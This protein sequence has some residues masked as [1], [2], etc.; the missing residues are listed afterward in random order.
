MP[1]PADLTVR[2]L[3]TTGPARVTPDQPVQ[4]ALD[5]MNSRRVGAVLVADADDKLVG[6]FTE[7]DFLRQAVQAGSQWHTSPIRDWM[8]P[9]PYTIHPD[10]G[11]EEAVASLERLRVRHLPVVENGRLVGIITTRALMAHRAE[12]LNEIVRDRTREL[13]RANDALLARDAELTH[14]MNSAARL[15]KRLVLPQ[16][17]PDWPEVAWG[18]HFAPLDPLGGDLYGFARPDEDHL[19]VLIAD[20]SGHGIPAAMVAIMTRLAFV[21]ASRGTARPGEVLAA[22]NQRLLDLADE[23]FVTAFYGVLDRKTRQLAYANAGHPFPSRYSARTGQAS[24]LTARGFLL[25]VMAEEVYAERVVDLE[26]GD[27]LVLFTDGVADCRDDRGAT[28]GHERVRELLPALAKG[29]A[30]QIADGYARELSQF[31]GETK[32]VDDMTLVV[33]EIR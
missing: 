19:G 4:V 1:V 25:G 10:A 15:Q 3:M 11:W 28:F 29:T 27:R 14:Y 33:A 12:H 23:R 13:K 30:A 16:A 6:I 9:Y 21:E 20:A 18:V 26:P 7:R 31:R 2:R 32:P 24:E 5:L 8:S 17:P 22:M